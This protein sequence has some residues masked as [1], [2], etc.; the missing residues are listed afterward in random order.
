MHEYGML[1]WAEMEALDRDRTIAVLPVGSV[2]Q[3]GCHLPLTTDA[4]VSLRLC[5]PLAEAIPEVSWLALPPITY[6]YAKHSEIFPG[7]M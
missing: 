1:T 3:H 2:E 6:G 4:L 7:T 5:K